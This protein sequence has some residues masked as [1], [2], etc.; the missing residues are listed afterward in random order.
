MSESTMKVGSSASTESSKDWGELNSWLTTP[1]SWA[2]LNGNLE[3]QTQ[4]VEEE[5]REG[6]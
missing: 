6:E 4:G 5:T 3:V 1:Q 2:N